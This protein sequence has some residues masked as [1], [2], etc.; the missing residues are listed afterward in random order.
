[1]F[2][3]T[4]TDNTIIAAFDG[5][6]FTLESPVQG[7]EPSEIA[8]WAEEWSTNILESLEAGQVDPGI[9]QIHFAMDL[10]AHAIYAAQEES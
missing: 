1:M 3:I 4:R 5:R 8:K 7:T 9:T 10:M 6:E 2:K